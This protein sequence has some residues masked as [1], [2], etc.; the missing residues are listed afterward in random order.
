MTTERET[1]MM[2]IGEVL[3]WG[4]NYRRELQ[5]G[6]LL[7]GSPGDNAWAIAAVTTGTAPTLGDKSVNS[8]DVTLDG[9]VVPAYMLTAQFLD[10]TS[11]TAGDYVVTNTVTTTQGRTFVKDFLLTVSV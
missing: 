7:T 8:A 3:D 10:A 5:F 9:E 4:F 6:D 2:R 11:A 1:K